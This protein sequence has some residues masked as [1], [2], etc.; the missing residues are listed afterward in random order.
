[1]MYVCDVCCV[2]ACGCSV[3]AVAR[4]C[5]VRVC[6]MNEFLTNTQLPPYLSP[7]VGYHCKSDGRRSSSTSSAL[8]PLALLAFF[9]FS[10]VPL[11]RGLRVAC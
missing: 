7:S 6:K 4:E 10:L 3:C 1:M 11:F 2:C 8:A 5:S 9:S